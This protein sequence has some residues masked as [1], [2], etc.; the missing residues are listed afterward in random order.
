[1]S[2]GKASSSDFSELT[3]IAER[4]RGGV[5]GGELKDETSR[6]C[7]TTILFLPIIRV[8]LINPNPSPTAVSE[9]AR[10]SWYPRPLPIAITM[11]F[12]KVVLKNPQKDW[13][14]RRTKEGW[15]CPVIRGRAEQIIR[16]GR[17]WAK[18]STRYQ[19]KT[20]QINTT[21][22]YKV[23]KSNKDTSKPQ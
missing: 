4:L 21:H 10:L 22:T 9:F 18:T 16:I 3:F 11:L 12:Q 1:M 7:E 19:I 20:I 14:F 17:K 5:V 8:E 2:W 23:K 13:I 6:Q 15:F